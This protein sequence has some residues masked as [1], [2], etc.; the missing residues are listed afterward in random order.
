MTIPSKEVIDLIKD[1]ETVKIIATTDENGNPH[2]VLRESLTILDDGTL[3]Y[4]EPFESSH[5]NSNILES[6]WFNKDV[7]VLVHGKNGVSY[8]IKGRPARY[9]INGPLYEQFYLNEIETQNSYA[10]LAG[11]WL[12]TPKEIQNETYSV[13]REEEIKKHPHFQH[14]DRILDDKN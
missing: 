14:L 11:V 2:A 5:A 13:K 3:A 9:V 6:L 10:D 12:I 4:G 8:Q 1:S 7:S